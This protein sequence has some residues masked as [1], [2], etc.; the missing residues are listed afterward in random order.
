MASFAW[1]VFSSSGPPPTIS[2]ADQAVA[3][4]Q[5]PASGDFVLRLTITDGQGAQDFADVTV[6]PT[7]AATTAVAPLASTACPTVI[8]VADTQPPSAPG[9][10][11]ASPASSGQINLSWTASTDNVAV[12][13]YLLERCQGAG[14]SNFAQVATPNVTTYSDA[15]LVAGTSYS[16]RVRATDAANNLSG[17]S[18]TAITNAQTPSSTPSGSSG[19]K[20][21]GGGI[22]LLDLLVLGAAL[23][24]RGLPRGR[25]SSSPPL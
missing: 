3:S 4:V 12:T 11:V 20:H 6:T 5:V 15:G 18:N 21:G 9:G 25:L 14:C 8:T 23:A 22:L 10:L 13:G 7:A 1:S 24:R 17:Y 16:Y 19:G 2:N